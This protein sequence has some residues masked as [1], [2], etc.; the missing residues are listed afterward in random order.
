MIYYVQLEQDKFR[1]FMPVLFL[2]DYLICVILSLTCA[3]F[4]NCT[5]LLTYIGHLWY[6]TVYYMLKIVL[7]S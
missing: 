4:F 6:R 3:M 7:L 2:C 5:M 1:M